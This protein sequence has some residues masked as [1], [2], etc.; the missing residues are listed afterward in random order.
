MTLNF[1]YMSEFYY[2]VDNRLT[3]PAYGILNGQIRWTPFD[4]RYTIDV[5]G[6]NLTGRKYTIAQYAQ[7]GISE[8]YVAGSP[9]M[10]GIEF[11]AKL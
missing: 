8:F 3:Q 6:E 10:Y 4:G 1:S 11:R 7:A 9:L 2:T 5:F